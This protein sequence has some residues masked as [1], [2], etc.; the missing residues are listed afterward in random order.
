MFDDEDDEGI[1]IFALR[2]AAEVVDDED[3]KELFE[4]AVDLL[5]SKENSEK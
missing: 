3:T 1:F 4:R 5:S 2:R